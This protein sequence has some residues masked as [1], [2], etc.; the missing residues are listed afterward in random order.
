MAADEAPEAETTGVPDDRGLDAADVRDDQPF[1]R[2]EASEEGAVCPGRRRENEHI[3]LGRGLPD[4]GAGGRDRSRRR[5]ATENART[6]DT[7]HA[8]ARAAERPGEGA[9]DEAQARHRHRRPGLHSSTSAF[10]RNSGSR[11]E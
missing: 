9:A 4:V 10:S 2:G 5:S 3:G 11:L 8:V 6:V 1:E 7:D